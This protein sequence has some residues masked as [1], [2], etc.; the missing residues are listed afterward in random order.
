LAEVVFLY[1]K[2]IQQQPYGRFQHIQGILHIITFIL[3]PFDGAKLQTIFLIT[4]EKSIYFINSIELIEFVK[5]IKKN[6]RII[7]NSK[8]FH[9][10]APE[11]K[12]KNL[13]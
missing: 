7:R 10:F 3:F 2:E 1:F 6:K 5:I 12:R 4:K 8:W 9:T 13:N 11:N